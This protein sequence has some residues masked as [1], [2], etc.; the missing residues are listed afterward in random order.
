VDPSTLQ[1]TCGDGVSYLRCSCCETHYGT[2]LAGVLVDWS[3][4]SK[5]AMPVN[6]TASITLVGKMVYTGP[7]GHRRMIRGRGV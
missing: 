1:I 7:D 6:R 2:V 5:Y 4:P 3:G